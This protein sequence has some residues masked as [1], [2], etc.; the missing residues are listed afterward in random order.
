M[1]SVSDLYEYNIGLLQGESFLTILFSFFIQ[2]TELFLQKNTNECFTLGQ[3]IYYSFQTTP[4]L[5]PLPL[6]AYNS[7]YM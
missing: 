6:Q 1:N 5:F 3:F 7:Y 2:D 4:S